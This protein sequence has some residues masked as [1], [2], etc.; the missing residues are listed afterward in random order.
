MD[1]DYKFLKKM[2]AEYKFLKNWTS[3]WKHIPEFPSSALEIPSPAL[4][5]DDTGTIKDAI[6]TSPSG[7]RIKGRR[8]VTS[9]KTKL[10]TMLKNYVKGLC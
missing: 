1:A 6:G 9:K 2:E 7:Y 5:P 4:A 8:P 10:K 3:S